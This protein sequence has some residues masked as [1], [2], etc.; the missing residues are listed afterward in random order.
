MTAEQILLPTP[1]DGYCLFYSVMAAGDQ[2]NW[3]WKRS[4]LGFSADRNSEKAETSLARKWKTEKT[5]KYFWARQ[6]YWSPSL[7]EPRSRSAPE[8]VS[9]RS[10]QRNEQSQPTTSTTSDRIRVNAD[11]T[12]MALGNDLEKVSDDDASTSCSDSESTTTS[13]GSTSSY[14]DSKGSGCSSKSLTHASLAPSL[15][16]SSNLHAPDR[17]ELARC[18]EPSIPA[19]HTNRIV[20]D[21]GIALHLLT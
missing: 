18:S 10:V 8:E 9:D 2:D 13:S 20:N 5:N 15:S 7:A 1:P 4:A 17:R 14:S 12:F 11:G 3:R 16:S 19:R 6:R 21:R